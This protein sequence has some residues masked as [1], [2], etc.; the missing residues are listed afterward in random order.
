MRKV[1]LVLVVFFLFVVSI[2]LTFGAQVSGQAYGED[3]ELLRNVIVEITTFPKQTVVSKDGTYSFTLT[4][5]RY[6]LTAYH[7]LQNGTIQFTTKEVV[8]S[9][10]GEYIVDLI[11]NTV[12]TGDAP[13]ETLPVHL[14]ILKGL[15]DNF[16]MVIILIVA[17]VG[18][19]ITII[20]LKHKKPKEEKVDKSLNQMIVI[21]KKSGGR[22]TQKEL[23]I[24]MPTL[25]E[26]KISLMITELESKGILKKIKKGRGNIIIVKRKK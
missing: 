13:P 26:A 19:S 23:R 22:A 9:E 24:Q 14:K 3:Y 15:Q 25:S 2:D 5:G 7:R 21:L 8:V 12:F 1:P 17:A 11:L 4:P 18:I 10:S 20:L 6:E 16:L